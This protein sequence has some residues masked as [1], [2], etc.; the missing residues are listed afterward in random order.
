MSDEFRGFPPK[1]ENL[2]IL[3][4]KEAFFACLNCLYARALAE[5]E[6]GKLSVFSVVLL[7]LVFDE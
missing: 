3:C 6:I 2:S 7:D 4:L 1:F 5:T